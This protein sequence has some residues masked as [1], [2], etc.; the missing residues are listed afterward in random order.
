[1]PFVVASASAPPASSPSFFRYPF[2]KSLRSSTSTGASSVPAISIPKSPARRSDFDRDAIPLDS[3][4]PCATCSRR[5]STKRRWISSPLAC[6]QPSASHRLSSSLCSMI[7]SPA[8]LNASS[9]THREFPG[10]P[11]RQPPKGHDDGYYTAHTED[12]PEPTCGG[13]G[14]VALLEPRLKHRVRTVRRRKESNYGCQNHHESEAAKYFS[15]WHQ[16]SAHHEKERPE[17]CADPHK[18]SPILRSRGKRL[19]QR[20]RQCDRP[21]GNLRERFSKVWINGGGH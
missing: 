17:Y 18:E 15:F 20:L 8:R 19:C 4:T 9:L 21:R 2:Q 6:N 3:G 7:P 5:S 11:R 10:L 16:T 13:P 14:E 1:M 12:R